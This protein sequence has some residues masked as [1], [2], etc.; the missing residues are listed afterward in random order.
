M[1]MKQR[2]LKIFRKKLRELIPSGT[3][4]QGTLKKFFRM[5]KL[6]TEERPNHQEKQKATDRANVWANIRFCLKDY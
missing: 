6:I 2:Y 1:K 4:V 5:R 3:A